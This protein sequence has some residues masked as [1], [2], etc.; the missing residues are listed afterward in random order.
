M[1]LAEVAPTGYTVDYAGQSRQFVQESGGF[2]PTLLFAVII[3]FLALAAQFESF[4]DPVVILVSVPLAL[5]GALIF[6]NLGFATL[7]IYTAGRA[8]D[9]DGPRSASTAS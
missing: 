1:H 9:A 6:I 5:F 4:R 7:N 8:G 3:V 2:V